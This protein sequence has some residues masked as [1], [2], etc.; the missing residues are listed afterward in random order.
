MAVSADGSKLAASVYGGGVWIAQLTS[1]P[2]VDIA[3]ATGGLK[4]SWI[5]PPTNFVLQSSSDLSA[6]EDLTNTPILNLT[7][8]Q[9]E[10]A[11]PLPEGNAFFRLKTP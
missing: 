9:D 1:A 3:P 11:L 2:Q 6:W 10:V 4:L 8:L 7:N 5:L